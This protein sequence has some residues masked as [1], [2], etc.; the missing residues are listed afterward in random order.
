MSRT[1]IY[2]DS[3]I[4][5]VAK[6]EAVRIWGEIEAMQKARVGSF[7]HDREMAL[8]RN[9]PN[10][11]KVYGK[12]VARRVEHAI[13]TRSPATL[14]PDCRKPLEA[15]IIEHAIKR[16]GRLRKRDRLSMW[17]TGFAWS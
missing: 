14:H 5:T 4:E 13:M 16:H 15:S 17:L 9:I 8:A 1:R 11:A 7:Y 3:N 2:E 12:E 6:I 10:I